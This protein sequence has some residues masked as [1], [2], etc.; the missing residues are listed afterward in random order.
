MLK[1]V[2]PLET[3]GGDVGECE[4]AA[5]GSEI[6]TRYSVLETLTYQP[7]INQIK[8]KSERL[9][10]RNRHKMSSLC[11][12]RER[13]RESERGRERERDR[14]REALIYY[15]SRHISFS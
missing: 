10:P 14:E 13:E 6:R 2:R 8:I 1:R 15:K 7:N 4:A 3:A 12:E 5:G 11:R 9:L